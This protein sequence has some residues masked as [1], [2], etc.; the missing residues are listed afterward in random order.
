MC[1]SFLKEEMMMRNMTPEN[2]AAACGG[3]LHGCEGI[4]GQEVTL[5]TTDSRKAVPGALYIPMKG[6]RDGHD[7][8]PGAMAAGAMLTLTE[9]AEAAAG[10]PYIKVARCEIAIQRIAE[11]YREQFD[12]PVVGIT[13]SVGKTSTKEMIASM[14]AEKY[15]V[16]KTEKNFNNNLGLPLTVFNLRPEHTCAVLEM[17]ISHFG[18]MTDLARTARP[19]IMVI[20]NIGNCHLEFLGDRDGV[21]EAKTE[22]F[23]YLRSG[24]TVV[25]NGD[26]DKLANVR[27]VHGRVPVFYGHSP[28]CRVTVE[29]ETPCGFEGTDIIASVDDNE[30]PIH[31]PFAGEH[32]VMNALAAAAV[33][34]LLGLTEEEIA[35]G[36]AKTPA[37]EGR[38]RVIRLAGRTVIDDCYNANPVSMKAAVRTLAMAEGRKVAVLGDM[39]ELGKDEEALHFETGEAAGAQGLDLYVTVGKLAAKIAVGVRSA[40]PH[41]EVREFESVEDCLSELPGLLHT[42]DTVLVK[43]SHFMHFERI[44]E[45]LVKEA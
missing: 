42:G 38:H 10:F 6:N 39:G 3:T 12:I 15:N 17:G 11:F 13:G 24:G 35:R 28:R 25:L 41:A 30:M 5:V 26:D 2:I 8:I 32:M 31:V 21:F 7:F 19:D 36:I 20:T 1:L 14:L 37:S 9:R 18:E 44:V 23:E 34:T 4:L 45:A 16:L 33:G 40:D 43:A 29:N 27:E 22:C